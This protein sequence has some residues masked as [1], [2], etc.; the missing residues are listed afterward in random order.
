MV[1][2]TLFGDGAMTKAGLID[3]PRCELCEG[4]HT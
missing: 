1:G 3:I 2:E 4:S